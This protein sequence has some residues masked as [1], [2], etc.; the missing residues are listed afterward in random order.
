MLRFPTANPPAA[1]DEQ[2][3]LSSRFPAATKRS[4][5]SWSAY[6]THCFCWCPKAPPCRFLPDVERVHIDIFVPILEELGRKLR[7]NAFKSSVCP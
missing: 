3:S 4:R 2:L 5:S 6:P 1:A 7:S